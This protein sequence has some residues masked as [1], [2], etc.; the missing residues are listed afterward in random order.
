[1]LDKQIRKTNLFFNLLININGLRFQN[2]HV[3]TKSL[4]QDIY[5]MLETVMKSLF[6]EGLGYHEYTG[7]E[8]VSAPNEVAPNSVILFDGIPWKRED[9]IRKDFAMGIHS[10]ADTFYLCTVTAKYQSTLFERTV[11]L[12]HAPNDDVNTDIK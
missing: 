3:F 9:N 2:V 5:K 1:M 7:N 6:D 4:I 12:R 11:N 8:E 10:V